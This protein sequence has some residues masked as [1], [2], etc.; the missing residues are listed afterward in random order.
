MSCFHK[1]IRVFPYGSNVFLTRVVFP[2]AVGERITKQQP[3]SCVLI[4]TSLNTGPLQDASQTGIPGVGEGGREEGAVGQHQRRA[5]LSVGIR[6]WNS[7][8]CHEGPLISTP[9]S[10]VMRP[11]L[12]A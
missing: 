5:Q 7:L 2:W 1:T 4:M 10:A 12:R 8:Q 9:S 11:L 6:P 3:T